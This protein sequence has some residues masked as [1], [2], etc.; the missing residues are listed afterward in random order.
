MRTLFD[1]TGSVSG[2][3]DLL[4]R[5]ES[6]PRA[7]GIIVLAAD[8]NEFTPEAV[9]PVLADS[10]LPLIGGV[11]PQII[12]GNRRLERGT[13]VATVPVAPR[14]VTVPGLS[15]PAADYAQILG[16][17]PDPAAGSTMIA[18]VDGLATRISGLI[19]AM[20]DVWGL[21]LNYIGGGA[22]S[23]SLKQ[24]PC[25]MTRDGLVADAA[26]L[27]QMELEG[28][29]GVRHGWQQLAGPFKVT[30]S[31]RNVI[32]SI[33]WEPAFD[34]Y[35]RV[36]EEDCGQ[37]FAEGNFFQL[38]KGYPFGIARLDGEYIVRDPLSRTPA[39]ELVCVGEVPA[40]SIVYL[41]R[42][43]RS[44]LVEAARQARTDAEAALD[45]RP[46]Q[47]R[48]SLFIDCISRVLFLG[49]DFQQELDA[50]YRDGE[51]LIGALT[52]GEIANAGGEFLEF[53]NKTA[54]VAV[55]GS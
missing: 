40:G 3:R 51:P 18:F 55:I 9:D 46:D 48:T 44:S 53:Y 25:V 11:F 12:W 1:E 38:A 54:V 32:Q 19:E 29:I 41:L 5:A 45:Q 39:G 16:A 8:G 27:A 21:E 43:D 23:L 37:R 35:R 52:I 4:E 34:V 2:L 26:I 13:I 28:G 24:Q 6:L 33:N 7:A 14:I 30:E 20:F 22:G 47:R 42:G 15:D 36:V 31:E 49:D 17:D 50:V 10:P